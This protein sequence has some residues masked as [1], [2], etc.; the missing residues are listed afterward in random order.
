MKEDPWPLYCALLYSLPLMTLARNQQ[1]D[2]TRVTKELQGR[3]NALLHAHRCQA[4]SHRFHS[5][6]RCYLKD[7]PILVPSPLPT[8]PE[9]V[10]PSHIVVPRCG[11]DTLSVSL[12]LTLLQDCVWPA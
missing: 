4:M 1:C 3:S 5:V 7:V 2:G 9:M 8:I 11:G 10:V 12:T 6:S